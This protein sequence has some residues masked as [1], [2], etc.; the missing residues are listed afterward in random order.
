MSSIVVRSPSD[1]EIEKAAEVASRAFTNLPLEYWRLSFRRVAEMFGRRFI[2]VGESD[3]EIVSSL[4][5]QPAPVHIGG[6]K[7]PHA[8]V[9]AVGTLPEYRRRGCAGAL[10]A[11]CVRTLGDE[12]ILLSSM[13]PF[14]YE[15]YRK[16]GWEVGAETRSYE[17][18]GKFFAETGNAATARVAT[19][20][21][22]NGMAAAYESFAPRH[23][24]LTHRR[25]DWWNRIINI[26][27]FLGS[28][29]ESSK[30]AVVHTTDGVV[31]GYAVYSID[32]SQENKRIETKEVV[33]AVPEH[34]R[35]M[36][37]FLGST[38]PEGR[39]GFSAPADDLFLHEI[40]NSRAVDARITPAF[41]FR[42]IDPAGALEYLS[43]AKEVRGRLSVSISDPVFEE[44]FELGLQAGDGEVGLCRAEPEHALRV[45][46]QTLAKVYSGYLTAREAWKLGRL[47][48]PGDDPK[49]LRLADDI[50]ATLSPYRS[51]LEPG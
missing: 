48:L 45:D 49:L 17:A 35:D 42:V 1:T 15:Y 28:E 18:E 26:D 6:A 39:L 25:A 7:V 40:P 43:P 47:H 11:G 13:W 23:N 30:G 22:M 38:D 2:L 27:D 10:M 19:R 24:C 44:G 12:G 41:Q 46:V 3:G 34:R 16:F 14:S 50:F 21:D 37:A 8:A 33:F 29:A 20:K 9:G 4:F 32:S 51:G 31:D 36:L 5:C